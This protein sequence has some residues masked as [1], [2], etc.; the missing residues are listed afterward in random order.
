MKSFVALVV[1]GLISQQGRRLS[2]DLLFASENMDLLY[3][4][5][6]LESY[7]GWCDLLVTKVLFYFCWYGVQRVN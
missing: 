4:C 7:F 2:Y 6:V 3:I 5:L 1:L